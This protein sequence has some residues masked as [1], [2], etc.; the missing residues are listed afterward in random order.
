MR[1]A[2]ARA[3]LYGSEAKARSTTSRTRRKRRRDQT[4]KSRNTRSP[5]EAGVGNT[6]VTRCA[7]RDTPVAVAAKARRSA[8]QGQEPRQAQRFVDV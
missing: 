1:L 5:G 2:E 7:R 3:T 4:Y 8:R 6:A